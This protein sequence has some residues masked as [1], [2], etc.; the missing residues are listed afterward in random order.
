MRYP[1]TL[2]FGLIV[3][4]SS[5]AT[6][7]P[8]QPSDPFAPYQAS[9]ERQLSAVLE[10]TASS[11][12]TTG[13]EL[14]TVSAAVQI[15]ADAREEIDLFAKQ[16]W[17]GR[18]GDLASALTRLSA[19]RPALEAILESAGVPKDLVAVVLV[20]SAA[21]PF[22]LSARRARGLWQLIPE[23]ARHYGLEVGDDRDERIQIEPAT[24]AAAHYLGDLYRRFEDWPLALAAYNAGL[25]AVQKALNGSK[26]AT[27]WQLSSGGLLPLETRSYVPAVLAAMRLLASDIPVKTAAQPSSKWIYAPVTMAN[28]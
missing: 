2:T 23:T 13:S 17:G 19:I 10:R 21:Q 15:P 24:R 11:G 5:Q 1:V 26:A 25:D 22:A 7:Q 8:V 4:V 3:L 9:L 27:F 16:F 20:E 12:E 18:V 14:E 28:R 6:G